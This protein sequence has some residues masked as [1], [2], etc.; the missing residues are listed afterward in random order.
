MDE[1]SQVQYIFDVLYDMYVADRWRGN[2]RGPAELI[3]VC[4]RCAI[5]SGTHHLVLVLYVYN[6]PNL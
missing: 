3:A 5:A 2:W 1:G 6:L 4:I